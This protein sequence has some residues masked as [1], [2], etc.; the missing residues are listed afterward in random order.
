MLASVQVEA[1]ILQS[2][3]A[4]SLFSKDKMAASVR[5]SSFLS[6]SFEDKQVVCVTGSLD[7]DM[8]FIRPFERRLKLRCSMMKRNSP[9]VQRVV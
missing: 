5:R 4:V 6:T 9:L 1:P 2:I 3:G 8:F 7:V